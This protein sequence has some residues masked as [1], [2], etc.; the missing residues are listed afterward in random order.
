MNTSTSEI[1][2]T[3]FIVGWGRGKSTSDTDSTNGWV[4]GNAS[5]E[6][7]RWGT[8]EIWWAQTLSYTDNNGNSY[9]STPLLVT[10]L[11]NNAGDD[12]AGVIY[13]DSGGGMFANFEGEWRLVGITVLASSNPTYF[14]NI[15]KNYFVRISSFASDIMG[16]IPDLTTLAG[17]KIDHSLYQA[18]ADNGVDT[19]GDG[20]E[21][22]L[23]FAFGGDPHENDTNIL[24]TFSL[25]EDGG[26]QYLEITVTR[27]IGLQGI[28]YTAQTTTDLGDWP[29]DTSGIDDANPTPIDNGDGTETLV[30][31][32]SQAVSATEEAFIRLD[33]SVVAMAP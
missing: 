33:V 8:N 6:A 27:P 15:G 24:P 5:T 28:I 3:S 20:I 11:N 12:E 19:D 14:S 17:W 29:T 1:E 4:W 30:Y 9:S 23:E 7:K 26:S 13:L 16:E 18:N 2:K 25:V 32:R 31:R 21:Q 10:R 22:L